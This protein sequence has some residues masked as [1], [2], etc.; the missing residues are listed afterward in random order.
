MSIAMC[1]PDYAISETVAADAPLVEAL[2]DRAF[3]LGRRTKT[4]YRFRE[5]ETAAAGLSFVA[6]GADG[7]IL[8]SISYWHLRI[9][10]EGTPAILLGPLAV[11]PRLQGKGLGRALMRHSLAQAAALGHR[12]A[13]LVGDQPYYAVVGFARVPDGRLMLPGPVDP[14]RL[15]YLELAPGSFS[16]VSGLV[17]PP[18]RFSA[19]RGTTSGSPGRAGRP[20]PAARRTAETLRSR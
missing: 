19:L 5:G 7:A 3:G 9:G 14:A 20:A 8:A 18:G 12:L 11:E 13:V 16:G 6:R 10:P 17:L 2:L 15:L 4:S 1:E